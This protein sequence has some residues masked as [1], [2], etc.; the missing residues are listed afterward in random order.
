MDYEF[1]T[2]QLHIPHTYYVFLAIIYVFKCED[3]YYILNSILF[4]KY[5]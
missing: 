3:I 5:F 4:N 1:A 2:R